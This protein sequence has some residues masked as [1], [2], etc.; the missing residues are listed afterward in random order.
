[1]AMPIN[2]K[3]ARRA[4][5]RLQPELSVE[6]L[7]FLLIGGKENQLLIWIDALL[8]RFP[9]RDEFV[10][11]ILCYFIGGHELFGDT[12]SSPP[13]PIRFKCP[14]GPH[15]IYQSQVVQHDVF[16]RPLCPR[17]RKPMTK[18]P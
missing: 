12:L 7:D 17:H 1:M 8:Y 9:M 18:V 5:E 3:N 2:T 11:D 16:G 4:N 10:Q 13:M 14:V 6:K 15:Y